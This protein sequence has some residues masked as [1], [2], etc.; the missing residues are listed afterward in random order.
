MQG[1]EWDLKNTFKKILRKILLNTHYPPKQTRLQYTAYTG[2]SL[3]IN[4]VNILVH[5]LNTLL[6]RK[7]ILIVKKV[8]SQEDEVHIKKSASNRPTVYL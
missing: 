3:L 5:M 2:F 6:F 4:L 1:F 8:C 7:I